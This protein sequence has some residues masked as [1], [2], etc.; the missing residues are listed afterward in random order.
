[1][2]PVAR[3]RQ[4]TEDIHV[5]LAGSRLIMVANIKPMTGKTTAALMLGS[6]LAGTRDGRVAVWD[7]DVVNPGLRERAEH[8]PPQAGVL[9]LLSA[10]DRLNVPGTTVA[11]LAEFVVTQPSGCDV[12]S[13]DSVS[14]PRRFVGGGE[15]GRVGTLLQ[16]QYG[17]VVMDTGTEMSAGNWQWAVHAA[18]QLVIPLPVDPQAAKAAAWMCDELVRRGFADLV[19]SAVVVVTVRRAKLVSSD[20]RALLR[21]IKA[22]FGCRVAEVLT[23]AHDPRLD[24]NRP[25]VLSAVEASTRRGWLAVAQAVVRQMSQRPPNFEP[26]AH[27]SRSTVHSSQSSYRPLDSSGRS[28]PPPSS[29]S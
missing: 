13:G 12:L 24:F 1:M 23:V 28:C 15:C 10:W 8:P 29:P 2:S 11:E 18:D 27:S 14:W 17:T 7:N 4:S 21:T 26:L 9:K 22:Y 6:V 19:R 3:P 5:R 25:V 20:R 16:R